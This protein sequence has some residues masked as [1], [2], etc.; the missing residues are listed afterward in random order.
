MSS[1]RYGNK[2]GDGLRHEQSFVLYRFAQPVIA[3]DAL[4][5]GNLLLSAL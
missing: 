5:R 2:Q 1:L 4:V 3:R